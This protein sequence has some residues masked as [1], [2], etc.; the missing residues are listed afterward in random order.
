MRPQVSYLLGTQ[1]YYAITS[2]PA[3]S[4][5]LG[6]DTLAKRSALNAGLGRL[7]T[8]CGPVEVDSQSR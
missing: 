4:T 5:L 3:Y 7:D 6:Y 8:G 1:G 2:G